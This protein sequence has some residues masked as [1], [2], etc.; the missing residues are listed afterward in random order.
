[1]CSLSVLLLAVQD[2]HIGTYTTL[3]LIFLYTIGTDLIN[4]L[5]DGTAG[6][7]DL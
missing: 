5:S 4:H 1:M 3:F 6:E 2:R 7:F